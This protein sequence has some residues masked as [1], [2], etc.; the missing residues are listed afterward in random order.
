MTVLAT[1]QQ[2]HKI[3]FP[4]PNF[5]HSYSRHVC[6]CRYAYLLTDHDQYNVFH[7]WYFAQDTANKRKSYRGADLAQH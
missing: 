6:D 1:S 5:P 3:R 7:Q 2:L 4:T